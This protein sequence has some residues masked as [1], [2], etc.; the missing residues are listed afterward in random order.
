MAQEPEIVEW[1]W[2]GGNKK[3][4]HW[5]HISKGI[6][7]FILLAL[8]A[9]IMIAPLL[10]MVSTSIK[11]RLE[12]FALPP[13]WIPETINWSKYTEIWVKGPVL[14]GIINSLIVTVSVTAGSTF[15]SSL[16]AFAF[17]RLRFPFKKTIFLVLLGTTM[18]PY[19][20]VMIPQFVMFSC[21]GWVDT[22]KPLIVPGILGNVI[23]IFFLRQ[24]I[25]S[26][27]PEE[28]IEAAKID[29]CPIFG[30]YS[31]IVF[32]LITPAIVAQV[33]LCFMGCWNDYLAPMIYLSSPENRTLQIV[34]AAFNSTYAIQTDYPLIM[35]A[36]VVSMIPLLIVFIIFQRKIVESIA[37]TGL[38]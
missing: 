37:L 29:G 33:I 12:V 8:G 18:I 15:T 16:A 26:S 27:V 9:F 28:L 11:S 25:V 19:S 21:M 7:L 31:R 3:Y 23:M 36:S 24:Y 22:L 32:P 34:I 13:V 35:A 1:K 17:A 38:K 4:V 5:I 6:I 14:K 30:M 20:V 10:W 2:D